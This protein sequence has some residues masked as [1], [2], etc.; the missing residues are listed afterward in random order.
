VLVAAELSDKGQADGGSAKGTYVELG[1]SPAFTVMADKLTVSAPFRAGLSAKDYYEGPSG[2]EPFGF[3]DVGGLLTMSL[4]LPDRFGSW[5]VHGG[6]NVLVLG[7][8]A[9]AANIDKDGNIKGQKVIAILGIG[10]TY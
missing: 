4:G 8:A 1:V 10:V 5:N 2:D 9:E 3:L 7:D 6:A